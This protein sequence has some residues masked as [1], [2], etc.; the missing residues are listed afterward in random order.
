M[1]S[2][3]KG[4]W[5]HRFTMRRQWPDCV[6]ETCDICKL[7][8]FTKVRGGRINNYEYLSYRLRMS[9]QPFHPRFK[10]EYPSLT[11]ASV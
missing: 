4:P 11:Y 8:L 2:K 6:E 5:L 9:L 10:K 1:N 3:C 7:Q